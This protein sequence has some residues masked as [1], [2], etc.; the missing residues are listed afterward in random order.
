MPRV[1][2]TLKARANLAGIRAYIGQFS[3]LN[4]E[5]FSGRLVDA[6]ETLAEQ[7]DRGRPTGGGR[8]EYT[9]VFP[10]VDRYRVTRGT[11]YILR[12]RHGAQRATP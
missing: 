9:A 7:S 3:P 12:I 4:A 5:R 8:R 10:Y 1:V 6:I 11:V 2:W